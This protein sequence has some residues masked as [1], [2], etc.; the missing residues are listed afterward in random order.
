M[1]IADVAAATGYADHA[2]L[3]REFRALAGC[4][5]TAWLRE[6][7]FPDVQEPAASGS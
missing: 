6:Q 4:T 7:E 3:D 5:P 1:R 2:H